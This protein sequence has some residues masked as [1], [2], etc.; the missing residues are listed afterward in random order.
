M[1]VCVTEALDV[2]SMPSMKRWTEPG[3][4]PIPEKDALNCQAP[5]VTVE[6]LVVAEV[7]TVGGLVSIVQVAVAVAVLPA[8]SLTVTVLCYPRQGAPVAGTRLCPKSNVAKG[9]RPV[10]LIGAGLTCD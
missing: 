3:S 1:P 10:P 4:W 2:T 5:A 8:L 6:P 9:W 7:G